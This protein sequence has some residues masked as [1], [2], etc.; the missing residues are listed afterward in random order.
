MTVDHASR[1]LNNVTRGRKASAKVEGQIEGRTAAR[2]AAALAASR[3]SDVI[4]VVIKAVVTSRA[5]SQKSY[6]RHLQNAPVPIRILRL[7][8]LRPSRPVWTSGAST[9]TIWRRSNPAQDNALINGFGMRAS[10][11]R[12]LWRKR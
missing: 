2:I 10:P 11:S 12:E 8:R 9:G 1:A 7:R 6:R 5:V 4:K 3:I